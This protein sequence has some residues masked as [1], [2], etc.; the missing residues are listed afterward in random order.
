MFF[1]LNLF[2]LFSCL[3]Y[4]LETFFLSNY[5]SG[6]LYLPW[7]P[8]YGIGILIALSIF[9]FL[10]KRRFKKMLVPVL[11]LT[12]AVILSGVEFLGGH[13]IELIFKKVYWNYNNFK[14]NFGKYISV[15][16]AL[17]WGLG[18]TISVMLIYPLIIKFIKKIPNIVT[19]VLTIVFI[20]DIIITCLVKVPIS[21]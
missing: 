4:F 14:W 10:K 12:S 20:L 2:Y 16:S 1:Y 3:G 19:I 9:N 8:V 13:L 6:I 5:K 21:S 7:T 11:F 17:I 18:S 15:E